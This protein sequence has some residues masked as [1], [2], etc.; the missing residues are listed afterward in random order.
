MAFKLK[1]YQDNSLQALKDYLRKAKTLGA[2]V[3]FTA[4]RLK[5]E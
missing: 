5:V 2:D 3:A 4:V 1:V